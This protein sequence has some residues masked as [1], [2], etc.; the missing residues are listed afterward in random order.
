MA[1]KPTA[2]SP[3]T[4]YA[5]SANTTPFEDPP[6]EP[7]GKSGHRS[8][9]GRPFEW[10]LHTCPK[11]AQMVY[12][13]GSPTSAVVSPEAPPLNFRELRPNLYSESL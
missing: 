3:T 1:G 8:P 6:V 11:H 13:S 5:A 12:M 10:V 4:P 7:G 9:P 2:R